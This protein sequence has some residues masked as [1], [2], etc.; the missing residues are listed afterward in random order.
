MKARRCI[1]FGPTVGNCG[2]PVRNPHRGLY[3]CD[4]CNERRLAFIDYSLEALASRPIIGK[5]V[6]GEKE[7]S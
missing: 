3:W 5:P 6:E 7:R 4:S 1:G 2:R